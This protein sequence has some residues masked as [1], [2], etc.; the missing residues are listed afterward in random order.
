MEPTIMRHATGD[1]AVY[2]ETGTV[3]RT[4]N[5]FLGLLYGSGTR[6]IAIHKNRLPENFFDLQNGLAG[7]FLQKV[8]NY[9]K[10]LIILGDFAAVESKSLRDFIYESN[11]NKEVLFVASMDEALGLL[12]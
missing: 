10:R 4:A 6:T 11:K 12:G 5:D 9:R 8:S 3:V 1:I 2:P 7:E